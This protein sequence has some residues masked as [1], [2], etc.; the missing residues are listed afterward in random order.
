[1]TRIHPAE[2]DLSLVIP[3]YDEAESLPTL[4][5]EIHDA[6]RGSPWSYETLVVDDGSRDAT[7]AVLARL[8]R[9][10]PRIR[11]VRL[12]RN[13]GQSAALA[14]GFD[15]A[16]G[17]IVVTLDADLQNDPA[18][19]PKLVWTLT[20]ADIDAVSGV[21]TERH[22]TRLRR[23]SSRVANAVR[24]RVLRDG[25]TDVGCS[26]KAYRREILV[27]LPRF[28]GMHRF[29]PALI[30][31]YGGRVLE[32]PVRHRP[33]LH[34]CAKYGVHNRLWRGIADLMA[35]RWMQQRWIRPLACRR[36]AT[37]APLGASRER[38]AG[39]FAPGRG[40]VA[41]EGLAH[42]LG[43]K[44]TPAWTSRPSGW[45]LDSSDRPSS[46]AASSSNG[47]LPSDADRALSRSLSGT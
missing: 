44:E 26:L 1:M 30:Q 15:R 28:H 21:R 35:V 18:D 40:D 34:G 2:P 38:L 3:A 10:D 33:R 32:I 5:A 17:A 14:V 25:I 11:A 4:A 24:R 42:A 13:S 36:A 46:A 37:T 12:E 19:I 47:S 41:P 29:L 45:S 39:R 23:L 8:A 20:S 6:L 16:R 7:P 43:D 27:E 22:D 31:L 9:Q